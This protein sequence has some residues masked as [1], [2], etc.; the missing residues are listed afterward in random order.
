[1][2]LSVLF[3]AENSFLLLL[4]MS[5]MRVVRVNQ[6]GKVAA[7]KNKNNELQDAETLCKAERN[8]SY[9]SLWVDHYK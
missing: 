8:W 4:E 9:S 2:I 5:L 1:M 3:L 7:C 6:N